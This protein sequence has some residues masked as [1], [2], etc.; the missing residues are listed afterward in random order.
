MVKCE[1][2]LHTTAMDCR[3]GLEHDFRYKKNHTYDA[4]ID[5]DPKNCADMLFEIDQ[6]LQDIALRMGGWRGK[7]PLIA[8]I[9]GHEKEEPPDG[10][11]SS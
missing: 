3:A 2:Q 7:M 4:N 1:I 9:K 11:K 5:R 8:I 10:Q 6:R